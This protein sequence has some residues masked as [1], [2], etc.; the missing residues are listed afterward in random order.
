MDCDLR[1]SGALTVATEEHQLEELADQ[2]GE[3][4]DRESVR[5]HLDSPTYLGGVWD[6]DETAMVDPARL[7]WGL[8]RAAESLG[9]RIVEGTRATGGSGAPAR[10]W[11]S[12]RRTGHARPGGASCSGHQRLSVA[13][14]TG[15]GCTACPST[16]TPS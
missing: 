6:R 14:A 1:R 10:A 12:R 3:L 16:T 15:R 2:P 5:A 9:V 7:A 13:P 11:R 8:A 4:L